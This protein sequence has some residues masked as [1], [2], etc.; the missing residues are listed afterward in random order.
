[1]GGNSGGNADDAAT[2][3]ATSV[4]GAVIECSTSSS[5]HMKP[6]RPKQQGAPVL[7]LVQLKN[8]CGRA[9]PGVGYK[10]L[11][12]AFRKRLLYCR[13]KRTVN[14]QWLRF[15]NRGKM[16]SHA[17]IQRLTTRPRTS[18]PAKSTI[19]LATSSNFSGLPVYLFQL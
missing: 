1:M 14:V 12:R 10:S 4:S 2:A 16:R 13:C 18:D 11:R 19:C 17:R 5:Y 8:T 3:N 15:N 7:K 9:F 6:E